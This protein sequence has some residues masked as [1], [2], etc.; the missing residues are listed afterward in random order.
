MDGR[1]DEEGGDDDEAVGIPPFFVEAAGAEGEAL[2]VAEGEAL[3]VTAAGGGGGEGMLEGAEGLLTCALG[4]GLDPIPFASP[5]FAV[6]LLPA[7][8]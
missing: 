8:S 1:S 5:V 2:D 7:P 6:A 4:L 3:D